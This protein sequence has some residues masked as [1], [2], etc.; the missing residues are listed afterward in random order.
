VKF[1]ILAVFDNVHFVDMGL[2][3]IFLKWGPQMT[4]AQKL[5]SAAI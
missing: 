4:I 1:V 3:D 2:S 5:F